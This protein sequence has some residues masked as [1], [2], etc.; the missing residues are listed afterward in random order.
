M[1]K[2]LGL[3]IA[4]LIVIAMVAAGTFAYFQDQQTSSNNVFSAGTLDLQ[5]SPDGINFGDNTVNAKWGYGLTLMYPGIAP[6]DATISLK[7]AGSLD[8]DH[9]DIMF[10][11]TASS[12]NSSITVVPASTGAALDTE[13]VVMKLKYGDTDLLATES[14]AFVNLDIDAV[15][16]PADKLAGNITLAELNNVIL[17]QLTHLDAIAAAG[18]VDFE[19]EV[20]LPITADNSVQGAAVTYSIT[21]GLFQDASQDLT[22]I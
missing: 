10:V 2:I 13:L 9:V 15:A 8:S 22:L 21:F 14:G 18:T 11:R 20:T 6:I 4:A 16:T 1:K 19:M 17:G 3:G 5:S 12:T 7:N